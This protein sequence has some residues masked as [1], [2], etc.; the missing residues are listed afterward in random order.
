MINKNELR[1]GNL[2]LDR[3]GRI[4][5]VEQVNTEEFYAPAIRGGITSLPNSVIP[6]NNITA[7]QLGFDI[8]DMG[9]FW[10]FNKG[11]FQIIQ[12]K[13]HMLPKD[14]V[15][16]YVLHSKKSRHIPVPFVHKLQNLFFEIEG[17]ELVYKPE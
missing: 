5:K 14:P 10:E 12:F 9:D 1:F 3:N 8:V 17:K 4:C 15:P 13:A 11:D 7:K 16:F 2:L 6:L